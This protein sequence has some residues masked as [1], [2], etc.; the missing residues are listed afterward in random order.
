MTIEMPPPGGFNRDFNDQ[1]S[2]AR[3]T[4]IQNRKITKHN[5]RQP[6]PQNHQQEQQA[7]KTTESPK[8]ATGIQNH[9]IINKSNR[10]P[11][12]QKHQNEATGIQN[13]RII[14]QSNRQPKPQ[15]HQKKQQTTKTTESLQ[16]ATDSQNHRITKNHQNP[17]N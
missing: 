10:Q 1:T 14:K 5:N 9:R 13:H 15:N 16:R 11:Q 8:R 4:G 3:A 12:P 2:P 17:E 6:K 7:S